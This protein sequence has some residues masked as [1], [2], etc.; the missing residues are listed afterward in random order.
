MPDQEL[1]PAS[2]APGNGE[3]IMGFQALAQRDPC[4]ADNALR[5]VYPAEPVHLP[6][7]N[8]Q[9]V[10]N[11]QWQPQSALAARLRESGQPSSDG[12]DTVPRI[13]NSI[14]SSPSSKVLEGSQVSITGCNRFLCPA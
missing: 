8:G 11:T 3:A 12:P 14:K 2:K 7:L 10:D 13:A 4:A 1:S 9:P 6:N 5:R